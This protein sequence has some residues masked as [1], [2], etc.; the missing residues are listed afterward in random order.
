ML[1][2]WTHERI[3]PWQSDQWDQ[4]MR[5]QLRPN[6][7]LRMIENRFVTS[8][9]SF[10]D[11]DW[12]D[13]CV[14][15]GAKPVLHDPDLD[16]WLGLDAS[17]KRDYS[18]IV[19]VT[20][21]DGKVVLATHRVFKP[22]SDNPIN[23]ERDLEASVLEYASAFSVREVRF[24]PRDMAA[25][26]QRLAD[27][28][29]RM[30]EYPQTVDRLTDSST[31]LYDLVKGRNLVAY[32]DAEMRLAVSRAVAKETTRGWRIAKEKVSHKIDVVVALAMAAHAAVEAQRRDVITDAVPIML[33]RESPWAS[34]MAHGPEADESEP[35]HLG[36]LSA[37]QT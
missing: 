21:A 36:G 33:F 12:W 37:W 15:P 22:S 14:D 27:R 10:I 3:A 16:V 23:F 8:E 9:E 13:A 35:L 5:D 19:G 34:F 2:Y 28:G 29:I 6:A 7:Y 11:M 26:S 25:T 4:Q 30:V 17:T 24:D 1:M 31:A 32:P 18:A 20:Y